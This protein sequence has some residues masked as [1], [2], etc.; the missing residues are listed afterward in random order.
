MVPP[1][2]VLEE[3]DEVVVLVEVAPEVVATSSVRCSAAA[4]EADRPGP[5][6]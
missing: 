1:V 3:S 6:R 4:G 5:R 2:L